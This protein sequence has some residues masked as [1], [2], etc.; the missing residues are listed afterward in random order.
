MPL[1]Y[2]G[3]LACQISPWAG[4]EEFS[5]LAILLCQCR[6]SGSWTGHSAAGPSGGWEGSRSRT[7]SLGFRV[8]LL[9]SYPLQGCRERT[10]KKYPHL[11]LMGRV[12]P[13]PKSSP[14]VPLQL[15]VALHTSVHGRLHHT[16]TAR[17]IFYLAVVWMCS[18]HFSIGNYTQISLA[19]LC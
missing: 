6:S 18:V 9:M 13:R 5:C 16:S 19:F 10:G 7:V 4:E 11:R 14:P 1:R 8:A 12:Q 3:V 17:H 2:Y 15:P